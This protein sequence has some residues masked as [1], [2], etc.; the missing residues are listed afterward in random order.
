M[1]VQVVRTTVRQ[2]DRDRY[3]SAWAE[4]SGTLLPMGIRAELL[5]REGA[6]GR[7]LEITRFGDGAEAAL[8]DDRL[9]R[10]EAELEAAA[11]EREGSLRFYRPRSGAD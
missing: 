5:E 7:F 3:L 1:K 8:T 6:P 2:E 4:W 10:I 9:T 11:S